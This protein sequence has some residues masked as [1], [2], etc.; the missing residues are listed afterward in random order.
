M[1]L[2]YHSCHWRRGSAGSPQCVR[3]LGC[4]LVRPVP[5][6]PSVRARAE[7]W[8]SSLL[9]TGVH[10]RCVVLRVRCPGPLGSFSP[11][12]TLGVSFLGSL[13]A[14]VFLCFFFLV[15]LMTKMESKIKLFCQIARQV[16]HSRSKGVPIRVKISFGCSSEGGLKVLCVLQG[17]W[18][19]AQAIRRS[20]SKGLKSLTKPKIGLQITQW[21][22][23]LA[24]ERPLAT[25]LSGMSSTT[26]TSSSSTWT[27]EHHQELQENQ[28]NHP[29]QDK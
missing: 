27:E 14:L 1:A 22:D 9:F 18:T 11:V 13:S 16:E 5:L 6:P 19:L 12:C 24:F 4:G 23:L 10:A 29:D 3:P 15:L 20:Q 17:M 21:T 25:L 26:S 2:A 28:E 7:F 8:A